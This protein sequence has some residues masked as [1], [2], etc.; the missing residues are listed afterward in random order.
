MICK[1]VSLSGSLTT[2]AGSTHGVNG[3][4]SGGFRA[5][6]FN[7]VVFEF[8]CHAAPTDFFGDWILDTGRDSSQAVTSLSSQPTLP[9]LICLRCG[10]SPRF[11]MR[12]CVT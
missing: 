5:V 3:P 11:S 4:L 7:R 12:H 9:G 8:G 2:H 6:A 1:P 10:N